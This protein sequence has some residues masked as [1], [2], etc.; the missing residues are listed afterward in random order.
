MVNGD[1]PPSLMVLFFFKLVGVFSEGWFCPGYNMAI[2]ESNF[3]SRRF[4]FPFIPRLSNEVKEMFAD[5]K[6]IYLTWK[7]KSFVSNI[8]TICFSWR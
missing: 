4:T 5:T 7:I 6:N 8:S 3:G 1:I 2:W